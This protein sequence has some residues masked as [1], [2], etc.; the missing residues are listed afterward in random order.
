MKIIAFC[1]SMRSHAGNRDII[2]RIA[3]ESRDI[4]NYINRTTV[5]MNKGCRLCNSE[6]MAGARCCRQPAMA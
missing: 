5:E 3:K 6:I 4:D 2:L 1:G